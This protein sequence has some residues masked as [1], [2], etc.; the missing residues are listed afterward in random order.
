MEPY[1]STK[2]ICL[3]SSLYVRI[4]AVTCTRM[5]I[6]KGDTMN[7]YRNG[8]AIVYGKVIE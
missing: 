1:D 7:I 3:G 6:K 5:K 8:D 4:P 2:V